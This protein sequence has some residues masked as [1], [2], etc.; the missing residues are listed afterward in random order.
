MFTLWGKRRNQ[1]PVHLTQVDT[2]NFNMER[3]QPNDMMGIKILVQPF[4][5]QKSDLFS[6]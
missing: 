5:G 3:V 6:Q 4:A 2:I 1:L